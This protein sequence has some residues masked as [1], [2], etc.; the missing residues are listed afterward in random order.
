VRREYFDKIHSK[1]TPALQ[2]L[3]FESIL[4]HLPGSPSIVS[5]LGPL[6]SLRPPPTPTHPKKGKIIKFLHTGS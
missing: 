3:G 1:E 4:A 2:L 5:L 6:V